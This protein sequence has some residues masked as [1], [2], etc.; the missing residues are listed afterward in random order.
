MRRDRAAGDAS[1]LVGD[2]DRRDMALSLQRLI[3]SARESAQPLV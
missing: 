3:E 1:G 2:G